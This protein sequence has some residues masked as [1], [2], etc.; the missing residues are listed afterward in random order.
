MQLQS[1]L[2]SDGLGLT[3]GMWRVAAW[4]GSKSGLIL[5]YERC[6]S[7]P[8]MWGMFEHYLRISLDTA[9]LLSPRVGAGDD[10]RLK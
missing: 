10:G 5:D 4:L 3:H 7:L 2:S 6:P 9:T 8:L 1:Y